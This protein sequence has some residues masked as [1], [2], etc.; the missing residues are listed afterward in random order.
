[1]KRWKAR[2]Q[3]NEN[4]I[5]NSRVAKESTLLKKRKLSEVVEASR[6]VDGPDGPVIPGWD[7]DL[8][9]LSSS[10]E[11]ESDNHEGE[12]DDDTNDVGPFGPFTFFAHP[13]TWTESHQVQLQ[14]TYSR[15]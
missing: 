13:S 15:S 1:L 5:E 2:L 12:S 9:E 10:G 3:S 11:E 6:N 8:T 14:N 4:L 7:S